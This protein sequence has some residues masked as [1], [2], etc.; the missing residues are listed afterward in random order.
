ML[1]RP[2]LAGAE[3]RYAEIVLPDHTV[4]R[5]LVLPLAVADHQLDAFVPALVQQ[6]ESALHILHV[7]GDR[8]GA[9]KLRRRH[10][11]AEFHASA[12]RFT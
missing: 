6:L 5:R 4:K 2:D 11:V 1:L 8:R 9:R 7:G 12:L 3:Q 10:L